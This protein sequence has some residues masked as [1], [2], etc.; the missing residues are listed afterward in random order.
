MMECRRETSPS[1]DVNNC[2]CPACPH[3]RVYMEERDRYQLNHI[4]YVW[5]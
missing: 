5:Y 3:Y 4:L 2:E 1:D